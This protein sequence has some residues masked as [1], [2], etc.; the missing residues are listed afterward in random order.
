[1]KAATCIRFSHYLKQLLTFNII[2]SARNQQHFFVSFEIVFYWGLLWLH[3]I[4]W[5]SPWVLVGQVGRQGYCIV[6]CYWKQLH[7]HTVGTILCNNSDTAAGMLIRARKEQIFYYNNYKL[8][9]QE[10]NW[11]ETAIVA[12]TYNTISTVIIVIKLWS[13]DGPENVDNFLFSICM[14]RSKFK[15]GST[16]HKRDRPLK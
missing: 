1:M 16:F 14:E 15:D 11:G 12:G 4:R 9:K 3:F 13:K 2:Q 8:I 6:F 10:G 7:R 5:A